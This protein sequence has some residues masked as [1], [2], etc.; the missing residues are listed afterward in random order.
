M[1]ENFLAG[2]DVAIQIIGFFTTLMV[3]VFLFWF[4]ACVTL[5]SPRLLA[6]AKGWCKLWKLKRELRRKEAEA[7]E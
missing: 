6:L 1:L 4:L 5:L 3:A 2:A 7:S